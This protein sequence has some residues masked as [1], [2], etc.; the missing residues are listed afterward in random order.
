MTRKLDVSGVAVEP[1]ALAELNWPALF[2]NDRLIEIEIG[3]GKGAF[4]LRR[5]Q[6]RPDLNFLG[7]EWAG[8]FFRFA[9]DRMRRWGLTNVRMIRADASHFIRLQC[10]R[11]S[12][13]MIHVYHPDPWPKKRHHKRRLF[14]QPFVDAAAECLLPGGRLAV[15]TDHAEYHE[16]IRGLLLINPR[17][18]EIPFETLDFARDSGELE[19]NFEIKYRREGRDFFRLAVERTE[20]QSIP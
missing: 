18:R 7:I 12:L 9:A 13:R 4:L 10:P 5:A 1:S 8:E 17:F 3:V 2:G 16:I 14:Q 19:T 6:A 11:A 15:Q 20:T